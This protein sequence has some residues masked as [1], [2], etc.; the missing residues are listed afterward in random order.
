MNEIQNKRV[1]K[2]AR[3]PNSAILR[4]LRRI[5]RKLGDLDRRQVRTET[6]VCRLATQLGLNI[7]L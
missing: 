4:E 7:K 2:K 5:S 1:L 6:R 3:R